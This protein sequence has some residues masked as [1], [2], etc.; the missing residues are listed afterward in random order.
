MYSL[1]DGLPLLAVLMSHW[2]PL[3]RMGRQIY[4]NP[5]EENEYEANARL[6]VRMLD[7]IQSPLK[8]EVDDIV[9]AK[10]PAMLFVVAYLYN[11]LPQLTPKATV[12]F[13]GRLQEQQVCQLMRCC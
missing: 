3:T 8:L 10:A 12:E 6:V 13:V 4:D 7:S 9:D 11:T 5:N 2:A 1:Q